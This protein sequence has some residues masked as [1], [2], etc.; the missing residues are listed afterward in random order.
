MSSNRWTGHQNGR[1]PSSEL[2]FVGAGAIS[3][4]PQ[5]LHRTAAAAWRA[6]QADFRDEGV[7]LVITEGYRT[8]EL[9][10]HYWRTLRPGLAAIPGT[11]NH[12][13]ATAIDMA[14]YAR[15]P[16]E[17]RRALIHAR[18]F[19]TDTGDRWD[20]PWHIDYVASLELAGL[21]WETFD[22]T[23]EPAPPVIEVEE[24]TVPYMIQ[25]RDPSSS[26]LGMIVLFEDAGFYRPIQQDEADAYEELT[27]K[28]PF[29]CEVSG[30][31]G[32]FLRGAQRVRKHYSALM[33]GAIPAPVVSRTVLDREIE[34]RL[35]AQIAELP[36]NFLDVLRARL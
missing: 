25:E 15:V 18:G 21:P 30:R 5:Y 19:S 32:T 6:L 13:W 28:P 8:F 24:F 12:G 29:R 20:E 36:D 14:N 31:F 33:A 16:R 17:R 27:G 7:D 10:D 22:P 11:S 3:G 35:S 23:P 2:V 4:A 1:I 34:E 26:N 9:Q